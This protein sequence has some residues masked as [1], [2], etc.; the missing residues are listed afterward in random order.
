MIQEESHKFIDNFKY[1]TAMLAKCL[2]SPTSSLQSDS[3]SSFWLRHSLPQ[4][5]KIK[6]HITVIKLNH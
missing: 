2:N 3:M 5:A 4:R 1:F 6:E